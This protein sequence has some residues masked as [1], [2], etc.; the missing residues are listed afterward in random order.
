MK[1]RYC[2]ICT[3]KIHSPWSDKRTQI[4]DGKLPVEQDANRSVSKYQFKVESGLVLKY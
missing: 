2:M 1:R 4:R 3:H